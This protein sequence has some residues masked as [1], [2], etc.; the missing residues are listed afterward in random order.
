MNEKTTP[1]LRN[2]LD[3]EFIKR[4]YIISETEHSNTSKYN[5]PL[6]EDSHEAVKGLV[7]KY[8][9]R[10]LIKVSYQCAAHCRFCTRIRQI[11]N[12]IGTLSESDID[13]IVQYL[14][15]HPEIEDVILSGGD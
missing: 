10:A 12:P 14:E 3:S 4:Q 15:N 11:G 7:H 1:F 9:N 13:N 6:M 8:Q 5:D 2:L